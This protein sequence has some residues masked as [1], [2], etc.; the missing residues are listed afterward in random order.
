M[1]QVTRFFINY[2][3][4]LSIHLDHICLHNVNM[5]CKLNIIA[6]C[7][8]SI[9]W[10]SGVDIFC[11]FITYSHLTCSIVIDNTT[12]LVLIVFAE[13]KHIK[14]RQTGAQAR[15]SNI[16]QTSHVNHHTFKY[17]GSRRMATVRVRWST[18]W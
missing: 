2:L 18:I 3:G 7:W 14:N 1:M 5:Y 12:S 4:K 16:C 15:Y 10:D 11:L 8:Y 17:I 13:Q 6:I 9:A